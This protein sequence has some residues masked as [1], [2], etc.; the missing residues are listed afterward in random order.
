MLIHFSHR[1]SCYEI[2]T[3]NRTKSD[4]G[5]LCTSSGISHPH[6]SVQWIIHG[7]LSQNQNQLWTISLANR[8][9]GFW[10]TKR[11]CFHHFDDGILNWES[12]CQQQKKIQAKQI[13]RNSKRQK[14]FC[15]KK[16]IRKYKMANVKWFLCVREA[17]LWIVHI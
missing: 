12:K 15:Q 13:I 10:Y 6:G 17:S 11:F 16:K 8:P 7:D 14:D 4:G 1:N 9:I 3:H 2:E 5:K